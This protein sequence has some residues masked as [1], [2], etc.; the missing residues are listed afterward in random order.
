[1][2][3]ELPSF[4]LD[5]AIFSL[6]DEIFADA[7]RYVSRTHTRPLVYTSSMALLQWCKLLEQRLAEGRVPYTIAFPDT[8]WFDYVLA[9]ASDFRHTIPKGNQIEATKWYGKDPVK[10]IQSGCGPVDV[11]TLFE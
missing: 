6:L 11:R 4:D 2:S 1:M 3:L 8:M 5:F 7:F 10:I 9:R